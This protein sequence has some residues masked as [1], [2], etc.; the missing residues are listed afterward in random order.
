MIITE[1]TA[2]D[3]SGLARDKKSAFFI[4]DSELVID[5]KITPWF[6]TAKGKNTRSTKNLNKAGL[7]LLAAL[8][9][10][11]GIEHVRFAVSVRGRKKKRPCSVQIIYSD[12]VDPDKIADTLETA[13][14]KI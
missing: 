2:G 4:F 10:I 11:E 7:A 5:N 6:G 13:V 12:N 9:E 8:E 14:A 1:K 3:R